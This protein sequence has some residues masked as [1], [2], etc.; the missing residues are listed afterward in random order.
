M[1]RIPGRI[2][3]RW[4]F[5]TSSTSRKWAVLYAVVATQFAVP[6][7][8]SAVGV[9]LP[10]I[11][12]E[13]AASAVALSLV[14][15][16]FLCVNAMLLLP[17]GRAADMCGRGGIFLLG[18]VIFA[19]ATV[20]LT[21]APTMG[22]FLVIRGVQAV[23]GA[24]TLATGLALL[25][26]AFPRE[27]R[28][29]ALG[30]SVAGVFL[31]I[32][33]GPFVGGLVATLYGWRWMFHAGLA[34]CAVA[35]VVCLR[36]LDW[37]IVP[38][39]GERFD[40]AGAVTSA[41]AV[42]LLVFGSAHMDTALGLWGL[43]LGLLLF[44]LFLFLE[45]RVGTPLVRLDLF[46][47][48]R[49]F[50]LGVAAIGIVGCAAFGVAFLLSL[51]L[52]FGRGM[53]PATAGM[54]LM[55]QPVIQCLV[56]PLC[57]RMADRFPAH[58]LTGIGSVLLTVGLGLAAMLTETS[59]LGPVITLLVVMG[60]GAGLFSSPS[61][62]VV[63]SAV[64]EGSYGIASAITGQSR[65]IG[66]TVCM[67]AVTMGIT[68]FV[69]EVPLGPEVFGQYV[70]AMRVLFTGFTVFGAVGALVS[71]GAVDRRSGRSRPGRA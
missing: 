13:Y 64:D 27:E 55:V 58:V 69:G 4:F 40:W 15:S 44:G 41:L 19:L 59:G 38:A 22:R 28:G 53:S 30:I 2:G 57:G 31:G 42:G 33:A 9:C 66:M 60:L 49:P 18:L 43:G 68:A 17:I 51:Y 5:M 56:S 39:P 14:E 16:V 29:R 32:S 54:V 45:S 24:M 48:N 8:L 6:F 7:M 47:A 52:Q 50:A 35:V 20:G 36:N 63:M 67:A 21:L 37:R 71:F 1:P 23:G 12:R 46:S 34:P 62:V 3:A 70:L 65:T 11:G 61:M 26:D 10:A 25:Y